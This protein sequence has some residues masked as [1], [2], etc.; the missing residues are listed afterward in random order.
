MR[1]VSLYSNTS[2]GD[3][4]FYEIGAGYYTI[5]RSI[6]PTYTLCTESSNVE[7]FIGPTSFLTKTFIIVGIHTRYVKSNLM[8][9]SAGLIYK[10]GKIKPYM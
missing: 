4:G 9:K 1:L 6:S 10:I 2:K 8:C 7:L 5:R 3:A